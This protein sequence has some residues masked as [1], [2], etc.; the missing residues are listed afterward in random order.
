M[1]QQEEGQQAPP[2]PLETYNQLVAKLK[3]RFILI[4]RPPYEEMIDQF[5]VLLDLFNTSGNLRYAAFACLAISRCEHA[6]QDVHGEALG[7]ANT[8]HAFYMAELERSAANVPGFEEYVGEATSCYLLAIS[9]YRSKDMS[10]TA[11][12]LFHELGTLLQKLGRG[13]EASSFFLKAAELHQSLDQ[14]HTA[15]SSL[16]LAVDASISQCDYITACVTL[17]WIVKLSSEVP[18]M[19]DALESSTRAGLPVPSVSSATLKTDSVH[20]ALLTLVLV[21]LL[22]GDFQQ[23]K[24]YICKLT[25][26]SPAHPSTF[27]VLLNDLVT[28]C[29]T[30]D[31]GGMRWCQ[32]EL[33]QVL[34]PRQNEL[35]HRLIKIKTAT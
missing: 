15:M 13:G 12:A 28:S 3:K 32:R 27:M 7:Y 29:E 30:S 23:A 26:S 8:G 2:D 21:L 6:L 17:N 22:Q 33:W 1:S 35:V 11:A 14:Y 5:N 4:R 9:L 31:V 18:D 10:A 19:N 25:E 20:E 34:T 16:W 24:D